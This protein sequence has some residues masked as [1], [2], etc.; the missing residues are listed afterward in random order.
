M[1][2]TERLTKLQEVLFAS[3][4]N[5]LSLADAERRA[6]KRLLVLAGAE[7][8][9]PSTIEEAYAAALHEARGLIADG[10]LVGVDL[11][12]LSLDES[13]GSSTPDVDGS[14]QSTD[15]RPREPATTEDAAAPEAMPVQ[16]NLEAMYAEGED[17]PV[18]EFASIFPMM[19]EADLQALAADIKEHGLRE[20]I[21]TYY[22]KIIDGRN[23]YKACK[24]AGVVPT[25]REWDGKGS[26]VKF[27]LSLNLHR[28]HLTDQQ[29]ALVAAKAKAGFEVEA[30]ERRNANLRKNKDLVDGLDPTLRS[31]GRS[32]E[33]AAAI[34]DVS[35]DAT[36]K[37]SKVL[38]EGAPELVAA[39]QQEAISLDAASV[40][41]QLPHDEQKKLV[42]SGQVKEKAAEMRKA[43]AAAKK[44]KAEAD[45][46][47]V[48]EPTTPEP[49]LTLSA[50]APESAS[51][52]T[53][54]RGVEVPAETLPEAIAQPIT[55]KDAFTVVL[56]A[57][58]AKGD[59]FGHKVVRK[60]A[61]EAGI[62]LPDP[63]GDSDEGITA[64][65]E[66]VRLYVESLA[67]KDPE[68]AKDWVDG[69]AESL[70]A[71]VNA[72]APEQDDD[73]EQ[74]EEEQET[75]FEDMSAAGSRSPM[76]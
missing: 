51:S 70:Y 22:R 65:E 5:Y 30:L 36:K 11:S 8:L 53:P 37:A 45:P 25:F 64:A 12:G 48:P 54:S 50:S 38:K 46:A 18:H 6:C 61:S 59:E 32:A 1:S 56:L 57:I 72:F 60:L 42:E 41:A 33:R 71:A 55:F 29:R 63:D 35:V 69:H 67:A 76:P 17:V 52:E 34:L 75:V 26:L 4:S 14:V 62:E 13:A 73:V 15:L 27:I 20:P 7:N 49:T 74:E 21:W 31:E 28:R 43:K 39:A 9:D 66:R 47:R 68:V 3:N 24:I 10:K 44:P 23:R 58:R 19:A 16:F 2:P 40:I